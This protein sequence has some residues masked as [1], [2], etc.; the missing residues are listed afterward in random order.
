MAVVVGMIQ[1][2]LTKGSKYALFDP[3]KEMSYIPLDQELKVKGKAVVDVIGGRLGK[4]AG[5]WTILGLFTVLSASDAM[6]IAPYLGYFIGFV[7]TAWIFGV[8]AL[9]KKYNALVAQKEKTE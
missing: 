5:G 1:N 7:V 2:I 8:V 4:A 6:D 3:T 9:S